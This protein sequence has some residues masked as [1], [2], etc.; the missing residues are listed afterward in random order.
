[1]KNL[2]EATERIC[3]LKGSLIALD[4]L[5]PSLL[6]ALPSATHATLVRSFEAH[7]EATR[8]VILNMPISDHV[9]AA[10][11][12]DI[13]RTR[14][15]LAGIVQPPGNTNPRQAV[16][17]ILLTTTRIG[18]HNPAIRPLHLTVSA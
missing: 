18:G 8:T 9:P 10:F 5:L 15:V 14:A 12:R 13:A 11:E 4:V 7:A 17:A 1:M 3:E 2:Q 16:E 6:E